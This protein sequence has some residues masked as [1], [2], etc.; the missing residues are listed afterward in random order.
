MPGGDFTHQESKDEKLVD[1]QSAPYR[2]GFV[3]G[4]F[5]GWALLGLAIGWMLSELVRA[6]F[7][8]LDTG[9]WS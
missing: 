4:W 2:V 9:G 1:R 8:I 3:L 5:C 6:Y 7:M